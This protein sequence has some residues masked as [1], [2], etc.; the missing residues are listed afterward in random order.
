MMSRHTGT[1]TKMTR[2][3]YFS[4]F[5]ASRVRVLPRRPKSGSD[6]HFHGNPLCS[7][8]PSFPTTFKLYVSLFTSPL[9]VG[10]KHLHTSPNGLRKLPMIWIY[11][12]WNYASG[13]AFPNP[14]HLLK[15][16]F[17][18]ILG[19]IIYVRHPFPRKFTT[20]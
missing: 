9:K 5:T 6:Q 12:G 4:P 1:G 7:S 17:S 2:F 18:L 20:Y 16:I 13:S 10:C 3:S 8:S 19:S 14:F 11:V 15:V